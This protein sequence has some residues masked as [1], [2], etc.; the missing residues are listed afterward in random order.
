MSARSIETAV[1]KLVLLAIA[2]FGIHGV[3]S[4]SK[5]TATYMLVVSTG[6]AVVT[7]MQR[8]RPLPP[9]LVAALGLLAVAHLAGGLITVGN[10]VLYNAWIGN[11]ALRFD[12][13]VHPVGVFLGALVLWHWF[14][15]TEGTRAPSPVVW[16]LAGLGLGA[17]NEVVEFVAT[18]AHNG[19][20]VGG[21]ENTGWD[22]VCNIAGAI[23]AG[24]VIRR[25]L[26]D[27][28]ATRRAVAP[29]AA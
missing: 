10:D 14:G 18:L 2:T 12:H 20:H 21:Y 6:V 25:R 11:A 8:R 27:R 16:A 24:Q 19:A 17:L 28:S 23:A 13:V 3:A 26:T 4:G 5:T 29:A 1:L 7:L 9:P 15:E 22:L